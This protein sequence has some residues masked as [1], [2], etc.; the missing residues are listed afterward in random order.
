[1]DHYEG[2]ATRSIFTFLGG[3]AVGYGVALL[4]APRSGRETRQMITDYAQSTSEKITNMARS[5]YDS[6]R[7]SAES[8]SQKVGDYVDEQRAKIKS[9]ASSAASSARSGSNQ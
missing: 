4:L 9:A 8:A 7:Q 5:A 6:A 2:S 1:M 3:L